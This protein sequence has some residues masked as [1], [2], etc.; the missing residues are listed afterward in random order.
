MKIKRLILTALVFS[1]MSAPALAKKHHHTDGL[2]QVGDQCLLMTCMTG[3]LQGDTQPACQPVNQRF[4]NVRVFTPYYNPEATARLRQ[5]ILMQCEGSVENADNL[6]AVIQ[7]Y[8]RS[9]QE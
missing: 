5:T 2:N 6:E 1:F 9:F 4:F 7:R 3:K 8:G